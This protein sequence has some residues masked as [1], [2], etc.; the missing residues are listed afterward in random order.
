MDVDM[1]DTPAW[2][3]GDATRLRQALFNYV[4]NAIKFTEQGALYLR[5]KKQEETDSEVVVRFEVQDTGIGVGADILANLFEAFEQGDA[6]TTRV[7][8]GS[9]LG[10][11]ITRRLVLMMGGE[12]GVESELGQGSTFWFTARFGHGQSQMSFRSSGL[13]DGAEQL[14][15]DKYAGTRILL[16]EDNAINMEVAVAL[17]S[18]VGLVVDTARNGRLAVAMA[19]END[20]D[21][22]LMDMQ[23]PEVDGLEATRLIRSG[24]SPRSGNVD[25]PILAMTANVFKEDRLACR[26]AGMED[27]I[28]KPVEPDNLFSTI[29]KWLSAPGGASSMISSSESSATDVLDNP[30]VFRQFESQTRQGAAVDPAALKLVFADDHPAQKLV[31][32]KFVTQTDEIF[33]EFEAAFSQRDLEQVRFHTHKL[34]SSARTVGANALADLCFALE[35]AA[36]NTKWDDIDRLAIDLRPAIDSVKDYIEGF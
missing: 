34:K 7:H 16:A 21:L 18:S 30:I 17:L 11:A 36:H 12:V 32:Q 14:L 5:A 6:T 24:V 27:F 10:L 4:G 9:G 15:R 3:K 19:R 28:A 8:G 1:G 33:A 35:T 25:T 13:V 26:E 22:I 2:L 23:M 31:L 29:I 20:Y